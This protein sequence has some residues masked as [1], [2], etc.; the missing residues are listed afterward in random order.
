L[1]DAHSGDLV[2]IASAPMRVA[3][4]G[5]WAGRWT[6]V[7]DGECGFCR[8]SVDLLRRWDRHGRFAFVPFQDSVALATLPGIERKELEQAMHLVSP[9]GSVLK[10]A[11]ALPAIL[12]L[13]PGGK[14]VAPLLRLPG[15]SW[16]AAR[17]YRMIARS[18]HRL[19]CG[20]RTCTLG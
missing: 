20:S 14:P 1:R 16:L 13:V 10:G 9:D 17:V 11:A 3:S 6:L 5:A 2:V 19:G 15:A 7:Y 4:T 12:R 8:S 18:R